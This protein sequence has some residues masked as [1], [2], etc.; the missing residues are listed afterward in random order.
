MK[1][2]IEVRHQEL[3]VKGEKN[4]DLQVCYDARDVETQFMETSDGADDSFAFS[5]IQRER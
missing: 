3:F 2:G 5:R 4:R 1:H